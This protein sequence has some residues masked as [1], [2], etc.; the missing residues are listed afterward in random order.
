MLP[1][2]HVVVSQCNVDT[3]TACSTHGDTVTIRVPEKPASGPN[4]S[5]L[6]HSF[7]LDGILPPTAGQLDVFRFAVQPLV[8]QTLHG[9]NTALI[10]GGPHGS[11]K[12]DSILGPWGSF[13]GRGAIPRILA[14]VFADV[15]TRTDRVVAVSISALEL[16][17][18]TIV[19]LLAETAGKSHPGSCN[20]PAKL[21]VKEDAD[22]Y[23]AVPVRA[24]CVL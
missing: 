17:G 22:G 6:S 16:R 20:R 13:R 1:C 10:T 8:E 5:I 19:D 7:C 2:R 3:A 14:Q 23:V 9:I 4:N 15:S 18:D 11:G 21:H 12:T 24:D